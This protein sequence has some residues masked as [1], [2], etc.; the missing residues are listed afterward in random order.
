MIPLRNPGDRGNALRDALHEPQRRTGLSAAGAAAKRSVSAADL[1]CGASEARHRFLFRLFRRSAA[2]QSGA[3]RHTLHGPR[4]PTRV[5]WKD[6]ISRIGITARPAITFLRS[7]LVATP[8]DLCSLCLF[9]S[10]WSAGTNL[11]SINEVYRCVPGLAVRCR[12]RRR[13]RPSSERGFM[14]RSFG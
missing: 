7:V 1:E 5:C 11:L 6:T 12:K 14:A 4:F 2:F 13:L 10:L 9:A 3:S 8:A